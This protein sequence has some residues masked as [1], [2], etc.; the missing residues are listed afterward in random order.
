MQ[1]CGWLSWQI[2]YLLFLQN[3]R[4]VSHHIF[5]RFF[6]IITLFGEVTI[7]IMII[8]LLYWVINKKAG[9]YVLWAYLFGFIAM[10]IAKTTACIYRP[11]ILNCRVHPVPEAIPA[12]TG[13]SFPSGH[14]A[15]AVTI[16]GGLASYYWN[17]KIFRYICFTIITLVMIS[18]NYLGVHT[19]QDVIVGFI[20]SLFMLYIAKKS[21]DYSY[22][23]KNNDIITVLGVLLIS[24]LVIFY[25]SHKGYP[26]HYLFGKILYDPSSMIM[27][28][29]MKFGFLAG[30]FIGW[31]TEKR[32]V[33]FNPIDCSL[34]KKVLIYLIGMGSVILFTHVEL[35]YFTHFVSKT[36]ML[37]I[38]GLF[39]TCL[40]PYCIKK[41]DNIG[42]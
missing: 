30:S 17:N 41:F 4:D 33:D 11:W 22:N 8:C 28:N 9:I 38:S 21:I 29:I 5:D 7:P 32:F 19:P 39:I 24:L 2:D 18:R 42:K 10:T 14:T 34:L 35:P 12:A 26:I 6:E 23:K 40:Y 27:E 3:F 25:I 31:L 15:G 13:Y 1:V 36:I 20:T 37:F 16:W